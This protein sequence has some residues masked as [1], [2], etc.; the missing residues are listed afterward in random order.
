MA[1]QLFIPP[2]K[3]LDA[4]ANPYSG[5]KWFFFE[6]E[7]TTPAPVYTTAA[8]SVEHAHPVV[9]DSAGKFPNIYFDKAVSYRAILKDSTEAVTIHDIDPINAVD[10]QLEDLTA[11]VATIESDV[12]AIEAALAE[13]TSITVGVAQTYT[14]LVSALDY[15]KTL[16]LRKPVTVSCTGTLTIPDTGYTFDHPNSKNLYFEG[17]AFGGGQGTIL[18]SAM[19]G[20]RATDLAYCQGR[21]GTTFVIDGTD[22]SAAST[23]GGLAFPRGV[24]G[25]TRIFFEARSR[26]SL[27]FGYNRGHSN[28]GA[29]SA[30]RFVDCAIFG[31]V[32]GIICYGAHLALV[33]TGNWFGYQTNGGPIALFNS[34][35]ETSNTVVHFYQPST[36]ATADGPKYGIFS[37]HSYLALN[38]D[39]FASKIAFEGSFLHGIYAVNG[40]VGNILAAI[41]DGVTQPFTVGDA[42]LNITGAAI[43]NA[44]PANTSLVTGAEQPGVPGNSGSGA[45]IGV[46]PGGTVRQNG[47]TI[48]NSI[49]ARYVFCSGGNIYGYGTIAVSGSKATVN[50][51][52]F[53]ATKG[54][55]L[56]ATIATPQGGSVDQ[57]LCLQNGDVFWFTR[58]GIAVSPAINTPTAGSGNYE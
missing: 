4:N 35:L 57:S 49:A 18:N 52:Q 30:A 54:N 26:Y 28:A 22:N 25:F 7:T 37:D 34:T 45:L 10:T 42:S 29:L 3:A 51:F 12:A 11:D 8:L 32:W 53:A 46:G 21:Y 20:T 58:T 1:A 27:D 9:A 31:S 17:P 56:F 6:T 39:G 38:P 2:S 16:T 24:G 47:I 50:A 33:G 14:T 43:T 40:S 15:L 23:S 13:P 41:F 48:T 44:D 36:A 5:A 55:V 19:T